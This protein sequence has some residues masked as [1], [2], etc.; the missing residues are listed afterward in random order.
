MGR[1]VFTIL[2]AI[3]LAALLCIV[4]LAYP[5]GGPAGRLIIIKQPDLVRISFKYANA[6]YAISGQT[7][8]MYTPGGAVDRDKDVWSGLYF[9]V[10]RAR[11][12]L[13]TTWYV[14]IP[15]YALV[16]VAGTLPACWI[17]SNARSRRRLALR[18]EQGLCLHCGYDLTGNVSGICPEC[19]QPIPQSQRNANV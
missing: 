10:W 17:M 11:R 3:S 15:C 6:T 1:K 8:P 18:R 7:G 16:L 12:G 19:G 13:Q 2:S 4:L 9:E 5:H 14:W